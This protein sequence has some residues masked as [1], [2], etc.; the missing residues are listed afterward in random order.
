M[1]AKESLQEKDT[2]RK[3]CGDLMID[4]LWYPQ[5]TDL[6]YE[7]NYHEI[8][9]TETNGVVTAILKAKPHT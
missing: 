6:H 5:V 4:A 9:V 8:W 2:L 3:L 1:N 7:T